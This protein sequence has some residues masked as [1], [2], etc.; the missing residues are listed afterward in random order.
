MTPGRPG[1]H[2]RDR[3]RMT[4]ERPPHHY[5]RRRHRP[6]PDRT[7]RRTGG[8]R[9]AAAPA[10]L[11]AVDRV[12]RGGRGGLGGRPGGPQL[13][14][15]PAGRRPVGPAVHHRAAVQGPPGDPPGPPHRRG[16]R[17]GLGAVVPVLQGPGGHRLLQRGLGHRRHPAVRAGRPGRAGDVPGRVVCQDGRPPPAGL[18]GPG[19]PGRRRGGRHLR[20]D[21][22]LRGGRRGR[23]DHRGGRHPDPDRRRPARPAEEVPRRGDPHPH[24]QGRGH[25]GAEAGAGD[26]AGHPHRRRRR[27]D[28]DGDPRAPGGGPDQL[29]LPVPRLH[30]RG[31]HRRSVGRPGHDPRGDRRAH[32]GVADRWPHHR[33]HRYHRPAGRRRRRRR[34]AA[35]DGGGGERRCH[36]L[37]G[38]A[39]GAGGGPVEAEAGPPDLRGL[40]A[41]PG[42]GG[43]GR[44]RR[45]R[46]AGPADDPGDAPLRR[47]LNSPLKG[48]PPTAD[49]AS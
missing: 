30:R 36:G 33:R 14:R 38:A 8:A 7:A 20:R 34:R 19:H 17:P 21:A 40:H 2:C 47:R 35:E 10:P 37:H 46:A 28:G 3:R 25:R 32:R 5:D 27:A 44:P 16:D 42:A 15:R 41:R 9:G 18:H 45:H 43:A 22:G 26:A 12:H 13:L 29:H 49:G 24:R 11:V 39:A 48:G 4:R 1:P 6:A 23:R 31:Q